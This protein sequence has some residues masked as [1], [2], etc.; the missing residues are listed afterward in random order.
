MYVELLKE[1]VGSIA[2]EKAKGIVDL[3]YMKKNINEFLVAKKLN[4]TINQTRNVFYKLGDSG[5][6]SFIRKKDKKKGGWYTY[7]WTL[8]EDKG[9]MR[10]KE[11]LERNIENL[12]IDFGRKKTEKFYFCPNGDIELNEEDA[13]N[14]NY[15]CSECGETLQ[16]KDNSKEIISIEKEIAKLEKVKEEVSRGLGMMAEKSE[17]AK[18]R[19]LKAE[20]KKKIAERII[21]KKKRERELKKTGKIK[22]KAKNKK[23]GKQFKRRK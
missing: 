22:K 13:I 20:V 8:N 4:L 6:V 14:S 15:T 16:L 12:K 11:K 2:G 17:K 21:K 3:L 10:F 23:K 7:Y 19:R 18:Q 9:L 1:I 5:L